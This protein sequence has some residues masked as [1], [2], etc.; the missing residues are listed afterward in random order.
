MQSMYDM[1]NALT[2]MWVL[3][4]Q[5]LPR[6]GDYKWSAHHLD[7]D[8]WVRCDGRSLSRVGCPALY[9][10]LGTSFGAVDADSF[11]LPD[12]RGRVMGAVGSNAPLSTRV[13][14]DS[15]GEELH[16]LTASEMPVHTH[17]GTTDASG[18]HTHSHNANG[19]AAGLMIANGQGTVT[20]YDSSAF[21]PN[22]ETLPTALTI[23]SAGSHTHPFTT[24]TAG[25]GNSHNNMQ[26]TVFAGNAFIYS[27][28]MRPLS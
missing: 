15:V 26:P 17:S 27:A 13:L 22:V 6:A 1:A 2:R 3:H 24:G 9:D 19:G 18:T 11:T 21:E 10:V 7:H 16:Q 4:G 20:G 28:V 25:S 12:L 23:N 5:S 14:G 8:C